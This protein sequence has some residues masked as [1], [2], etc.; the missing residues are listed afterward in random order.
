MKQTQMK[1]ETRVKEG[2]IQGSKRGT[3]DTVGRRAEEKNK[4]IH[5]EIELAAEPRTV[6][7]CVCVQVIKR[8]DEAFVST[9]AIK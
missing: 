1:K 3:G 4:Q 9:P 8:T 6:C 5:L 7:Q 2:E